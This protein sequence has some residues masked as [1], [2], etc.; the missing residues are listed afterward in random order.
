VII[1]E[2]DFQNNRGLDKYIISLESSRET[3][4]DIIG[5]GFIHFKRLTD[6]DEKKCFKDLRKI[7]INELHY[8]DINSTS[9]VSDHSSKGVVEKH[10][11]S[12]LEAANRNKDLVIFDKK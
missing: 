8:S 4:K 12:Q 2:F 11:L 10:Y 3:V 5:K 6:I 9:I 7:F 1:E